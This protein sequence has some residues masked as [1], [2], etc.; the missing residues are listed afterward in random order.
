MPTL[1]NAPLLEA[2]FELYWGKRIIQNQMIQFQFSQREIDSFIGRFSSSAEKVGFGF[3]ESLTPNQP[4]L[5]HLIS[6]RF[7]SE[8]NA[9]PCYQIGLGILTVN[10]INA[11]YSWNNFK[12]AILNGLRILDDSHPDKLKNLPM[13]LIKL[14]YLDIFKSSLDPVTFFKQNMTIEFSL[15]NRLLQH[16][17]LTNVLVDSVVAFSVQS[18]KPKGILSITIQ[19]NNQTHDGEY[20]MDTTLSSS[21][22]DFCLSEISDI[23]TWLDDAHLIQKHAFETII[24]PTFQKTFQ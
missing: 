9:Y 19:R 5:P 22:N 8:A 12:D 10:Q 13:F 23:A 1:P 24:S 4:K 21:L 14:R 2:I 20:V 3:E 7:R 17:F 11:G 16:K 6:N 15:P 18:S